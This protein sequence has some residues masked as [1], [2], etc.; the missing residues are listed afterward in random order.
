MPITC[1]TELTLETTI[2]ISSHTDC[3]CSG[4]GDGFDLEVHHV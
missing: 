4:V 3:G 1:H 2:L